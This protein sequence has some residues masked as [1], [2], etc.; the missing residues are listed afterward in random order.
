MKTNK[1]RA[2]DVE[3]E[4]MVCPD[5]N[6]DHYIMSIGGGELVLLESNMLRTGYH[7]VNAVFQEYLLY[8][9]PEGNALC[10]GDIVSDGYEVGVVKFGK[11][12]SQYHENVLGFYLD[13]GDK[14]YDISVCAGNTPI[15]TLG[16]VY[17][18]PE[19][20]PLT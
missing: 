12:D 8:T 1:F 16:N 3:N 5:Y 6:D 20:N 9:D 10:E 2:W 4:V 7:P 17:E 15:D 19:L 13:C 11:Y 14:V 18:N